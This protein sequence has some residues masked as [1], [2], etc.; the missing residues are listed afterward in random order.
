M[1][2]VLGDKLI[3][4]ELQSHAKPSGAAMMKWQGALEFTVTRCC[5]GSSALLSNPPVTSGARHRGRRRSS[6]KKRTGREPSAG[7]QLD[8]DDALISSQAACW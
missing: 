3:A 4:V 7:A 8:A 1:F 5:G 6:Q 2:I